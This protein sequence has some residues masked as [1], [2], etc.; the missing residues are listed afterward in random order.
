[1]SDDEIVRHYETVLMSTDIYPIE[2]HRRLYLILKD[3]PNNGDWQSV[4]G[5]VYSVFA[6]YGNREYKGE[7]LYRTE[8]VNK[9]GISIYFGED[10]T[11]LP[12]IFVAN[13]INAMIVD[14]VYPGDFTQLFEEARRIL[15]KAEYVVSDE[16]LMTAVL[17]LQKEKIYNPTVRQI[18]EQTEAVIV[19]DAENIEDAELSAVEQSDNENSFSTVNE[20]EENAAVS[21]TD[22]TPQLSLFGEIT[23]GGQT[24]LTDI[25]SDDKKGEV[26][27]KTEIDE[28][29]EFK[30][31]EECTGSHHGQID[32]LMTAYKGE[33]PIGYIKYSIYENIPHIDYIE[34]MPSQSRRGIATRLLQNLQ[35]AI[36]Y[37][38]DCLGS[39]DR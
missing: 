3:E 30:I 21:E 25:S 24:A 27:D 28:N 1:M 12:W 18:A 6:E 5:E 38:R 13:I 16:Y 31:L 9:D 19:R 39:V 11:Y 32:M 26:A 15:E 36:S 10:S 33:I 8:L 17:E 4:S 35:G 20:K 22:E 14:G 37:F 34:V 23:D 2:L 29:A 7:V